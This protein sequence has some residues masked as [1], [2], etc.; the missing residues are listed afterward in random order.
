[1]VGELN[2]ISV[3]FA[4]LFVGLGIDFGIQF[5]VRYRAD[6]FEQ[7]DLANAIRA[8][9]RGVGW[10]LSLAAISLV[11]GFFAFLPTAFRGVSELGLIAGVGMIV[12]YLFSLTLL[13]ALIAVFKPKG[14]ARAVETT[15]L[16]GVDHWIIQNRKI[17]LI[18]VGVITVAGIPLLFKLPFDSNPMHLRS[19]KVE[20]I[21]TYLDLIKDPET[22]PNLI[23]VIAPNVQAVPELAAKLKALPSVA[24]VIDIDTFV[25]PDQDQKLATI[26]ETA[27]LLGPILNPARKPP[28]PTDADT[29]KAL[30][31]AATAL[32]GI[33]TGDAAG[34][35][36]AGAL[37][38]TLDSLA[39]ATP[40]LRQAANVAVTTDLAILLN[41]LRGMLAPEKVT[42][43][44]IP[45]K[46]KAEWIAAVPLLQ[47]T[48]NF[49]PCFAENSF[50][51]V[52]TFLPPA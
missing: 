34:A 29:V 47:P 30:K 8:A 5:A 33:A 24:R 4:A 49:A 44:N 35:K 43:A 9:A 17:V 18:I 32:K 51:S 42:L 46:L 2:P 11:A 25:P 23:D 21:S 50:S 10:S 26:A 52:L 3:A 37:S 7:P 12:A 31:E 48:P 36:A 39:S 22:S 38:G 40:Q 41:R 20:S 19:T 27:E 45:P 16:A 15:W 13:P 14:E 6:R 1:M 28:P